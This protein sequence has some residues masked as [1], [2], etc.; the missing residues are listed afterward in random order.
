[1]C[2]SAATTTS[3]DKKE[4]VESNNYGLLNLSSSSMATM[5]LGEIL[6][7]VLLIV[8]GLCVLWYVCKKRRQQQLQELR[9]AVNQTVAYRPQGE[10]LT[11]PHRRMLPLEFAGSGSATTSQPAP[12]AP[13]PSH[14]GLWEQCR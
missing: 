3:E 8:V 6:L 4:S 13:T 10:S 1:M 7:V 14:T 2:K 12:S 9:D 5:D 11:Y